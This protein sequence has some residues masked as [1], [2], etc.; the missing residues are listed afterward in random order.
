M[1]TGT[2]AGRQ[3]SVPI[4]CS[5]QGD[6]WTCLEHASS[7]PVGAVMETW[8]EQMGFPVLSVSAEQVENLL[9]VYLSLYCVFISR[10][11]VK[12]FMM[13]GAVTF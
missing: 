2:N 5:F 4:L 1:Y 9:E 8:T 7:K 6:L 13:P 11:E 10:D 3:L 12:H